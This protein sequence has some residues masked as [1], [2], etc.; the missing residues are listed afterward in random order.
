MEIENGR[1]LLRARAYIEA[2][3]IHGADGE[4]T[5]VLI[6]YGKKLYH[7]FSSRKIKEERGLR[8]S[9][10]ETYRVRINGRYTEVYC[11]DGRWFVR[12]KKF[13]DEMR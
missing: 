12:E 1:A 4:A 6:M 9:L 13:I 10:I 11:E 7:V 3:V 8:N 5:P 2:Q